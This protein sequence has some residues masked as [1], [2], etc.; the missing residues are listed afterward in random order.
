MQKEKVVA[1]LKV[2]LHMRGE[3]EENHQKPM[4]NLYLGRDSKGEKNGEGRSGSITRSEEGQSSNGAGFL[5]VLWFPLP[6]LIPPTAPYKYSSITLGWNN[7]PTGLILIPP[8]V[9]N[10]KKSKD[11]SNEHQ[12]FSRNYS[13]LLQ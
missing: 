8:H 11:E 10:K 9:G 7:R 5:R 12:C 1:Y 13:V 6:I 4:N 2:S 3:R